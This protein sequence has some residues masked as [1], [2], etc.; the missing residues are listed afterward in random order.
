[1]GQSRQINKKDKNLSHVPLQFIMNFGIPVVPFHVLRATT[2][3][4]VVPLRTENLNIRA[5]FVMLPIIDTHLD[6]SCIKCKQGKIIYPKELNIPGEIIYARCGEDSKGLVEPEGKAF[7]ISITLVIGTSVKP[8]ALKMS[9]TIEL[10][11]AP[12]MEAAKEAVGYLIR[13]IHLLQQYCDYIRDRK[14]ELFTLIENWETFHP[15]LTSKGP[16]HSKM[17]VIVHEL[18]KQYNRHHDSLRIKYEF[19][20]KFLIHF[21][22][23]L[24]RNELEVIKF[25]SEMINVPF[26]LGF[27][28]NQREMA[29]LMQQKPFVCYYNN[30]REN[31]CLFVQK[32]DLKKNRRDEDKW[33]R[34]V[35]KIN[36]SGYVMYSGP[37]LHK[38]EQYYYLFFRMILTSNLNL[39]SNEI[40]ER[41]VKII[42]T[43]SLIPVD[44]FKKYIAHE[45]TFKKK[46][47]INHPDIYVFEEDE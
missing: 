38:M 28:V 36:R 1:M 26:D 19:L 17:E 35:F 4:I 34:L 32:Y 33:S 22:C 40:Y 7:P 31:S 29:N 21:D 15:R 13:K 37:N 14:D 25:D 44:L 8:M 41:K 30:V 2:M 16:F 5:I 39:Q 3:T 6:A 20:S 47:I 42:D 24:Y 46:I 45:E 27:T 43:P 23:Y 12:S 18:T 11:G 9:E 10:T